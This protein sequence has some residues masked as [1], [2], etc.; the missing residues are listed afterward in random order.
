MTFKMC[1][2]S[3]CFSVLPKNKECWMKFSS[4]PRTSRW[5]YEHRSQQKRSQQHRSQQKRDQHRCHNIILQRK[6]KNKVQ[7]VYY[8]NYQLMMMLIINYQLM[9]MLIINYQLMMMLIIIIWWPIM[10]GMEREFVKKNMRSEATLSKL[11]SAVWAGTNN[12]ITSNA[13]G[14]GR[15]YTCSKAIWKG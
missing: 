13:K 15:S 11:W 5:G 9:I 12:S 3:G 1:P 7:Q 8:Y 4:F 2:T 14:C 6:Q 10:W